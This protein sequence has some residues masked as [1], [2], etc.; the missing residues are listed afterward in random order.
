MIE[1]IRTTSYSIPEELF[2]P[3]ELYQ[4]KF[5]LDDHKEIDPNVIFDLAIQ[6]QKNKRA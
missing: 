5:Y 2:K 1:D 4:V 3:K 6:I